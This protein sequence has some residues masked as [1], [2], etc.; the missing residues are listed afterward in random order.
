MEANKLHI[1]AV[2]L[3]TSFIKDG[4]RRATIEAGQYVLA[5]CIR[6]MF[7]FRG[8]YDDMQRCKRLLDMYPKNR[9]PMPRSEF[10]HLVWLLF[11]NLCYLLEERAKFFGESFNRVV[12]SY[13]VGIRLKVGDLVKQIH[14]ELNEQIRAR[15]ELTHQAMPGHER[16]VEFGMFEL[17]HRLD[18]WPEEFP[19]YERFSGMMQAMMRVEMNVALGRAK[20]IVGEALFQPVKDTAKAVAIFNATYARLDERAKSHD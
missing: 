6:A 13:G 19:P 14:K 16:I 2:A 8:I 18:K 20:R 11:V 10:M 3:D 7:S 17:L 1:G 9:R 4:D 15:G 5:R 12:A